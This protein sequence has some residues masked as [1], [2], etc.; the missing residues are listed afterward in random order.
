[1]CVNSTQAYLFQYICMH[2]PFCAPQGSWG[3]LV[4]RL[5]LHFIWYK[6]ISISSHVLMKINEKTWNNI[7]PI[8]I[9][10]NMEYEKVCLCVCTIRIS[11]YRSEIIRV[12]NSKCPINFYTGWGRGTEHMNDD[13]NPFMVNGFEFWKLRFGIAREDYIAYT[14][15]AGRVGNFVC[16]EDKPDMMN[17][18]TCMPCMLSL[19]TVCYP[20]SPLSICIR[21]F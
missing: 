6:E 21:F 19:A 5:Q 3:F 12:S 20:R 16:C 4:V 1:M 8:Y 17:R 2:C 13:I 7:M 14:Y 18:I 11:T 10:I 15:I 9:Y